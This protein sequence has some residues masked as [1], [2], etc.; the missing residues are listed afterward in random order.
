[1][2]WK[3]VALATT[4]AAST[5]GVVATLARVV[6]E[7]PVQAAAPKDAADVRTAEARPA[8]IRSKVG[9]KGLVAPTRRFPL[10]CSGSGLE[11]IV[12]ILPSGT[13]VR[14]GDVVVELDSKD[15][16]E[17]L[18]ERKIATQKAE[19]AYEE[20]KLAREIA[21][22]GVK[23]YEDGIYPQ[24]R[25]AAQGEIKLAE[26]DLARSRR[27][28]ERLKALREES[29]RLLEK[30]GGA[31]T[32]IDV[33]ADE[34]AANRLTAADLTS[35]KAGLALEQAQAKLEVLEKFTRGV[36]IK[37]C[38]S[39]FEKAFVEEKVKEQELA[40]ER[41]HEESVER[42]RGAYKLRSPVDGVV[43]EAKPST[44]GRLRAGTEVWRGCTLAYVQGPDGRL[45]PQARVPE[46]R[47]GVIRKGQPAQVTLVDGLVSD[48]PLAGTVE[49]IAASP[50]PLNRLEGED[51]A[52]VSVWIKLTE[53][54]AARLMAGQKAD[55]VITVDA[56]KDALGV[57]AG[58]LV[59]YDGAHHV[60]IPGA[61]GAIA[62]REV[63]VGLSNGETTEIRSGLKPGEAVVV[64][65]GRH[66]SDDQR[67]RISIA[68]PPAERALPAFPPGDGPG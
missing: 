13:K 64:E 43:A 51:E 4:L 66:L 22:I 14:K 39:R 33:Q 62:W 59:W 26:A 29:A 1:M 45:A 30:Q 67:R 28:A 55:V 31:K 21:E 23:E 41:E 42:E 61:D 7:P 50:D 60:G 20:A 15:L 65:P 38:R 27:E 52:L 54:P 10:T 16:Q 44:A 40:I 19:A 68:P 46:S 34:Q 63:V 2:T 37:E 35:L 11:R 3:A 56:P 47:I 6:E 36:K 12:S 58:A 32:P 17:K 8:T 18:I 48:A 49:S 53:P 5:S 24:D 25:A 57:P 9:V